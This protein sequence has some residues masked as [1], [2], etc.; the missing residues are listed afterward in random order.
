MIYNNKRPMYALLSRLSSG[1][2]TFE[3]FKVKVESEDVDVVRKMLEKGIPFPTIYLHFDK[4]K[5]TVLS[6]YKL[7]LSIYMYFN[8]FRSTKGF[9]NLKELFTSNGVNKD[10][11]FF[12]KEER[13]EYLAQNKQNEQQCTELSRVIDV[14]LIEDI[15][16]D[17][18]QWLFIYKQK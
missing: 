4:G 11:E 8:G 7:I 1:Q 2:Y 9:I 16:V 3:D 15:N 5:T 6:G 17:D 14:V 13:T 12:Y 18:I 10:N